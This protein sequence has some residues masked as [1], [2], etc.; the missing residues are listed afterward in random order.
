MRILLPASELTNFQLVRPNPITP[1]THQPTT[2]MYTYKSC[3]PSYA[4]GL[5]YDFF[6]CTLPGTMF[7][8]TNLKATAFLRVEV[9][10][11]EFTVNVKP[12]L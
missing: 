11:W 1:S 7:W 10:V 4:Y 3:K 2:C 6:Q 9:L 12:Q 5:K 8:L